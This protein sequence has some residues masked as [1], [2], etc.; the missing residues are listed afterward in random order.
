MIIDG[1]PAHNCVI[2]K[3]L[4]LV[5]CDRLDLRLVIGEPYVV[6]IVLFFIFAD[7]MVLY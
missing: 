4:S 7:L 2:L 1:L 6:T 5:S 3:D